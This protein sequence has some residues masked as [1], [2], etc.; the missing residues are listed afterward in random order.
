MPVNY[1]TRSTAPDLSKETLKRIPKYAYKFNEGW[2]TCTFKGFYKDKNSDHKGKCI[3]HFQVY[4]R[5]MYL[6]LESEQYGL[7][8]AWVAM[9]RVSL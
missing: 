6:D 8:G 1:V 5:S 4:H 3:M 7:T 2:E 9:D